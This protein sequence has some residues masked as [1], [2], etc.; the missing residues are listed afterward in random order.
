MFK[1]KKDVLNFIL[2]LILLIFLGYIAYKVAIL[3]VDTLKK[4]FDNYP[5]IAVALVTG[6]LAFI[7]AIVGKVVENKFSINNQRK[8]DKK[9]ILIFLIGL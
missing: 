9:Y 4:L 2:G 6:F 7:S 1:S 8:K 5:T 3:F